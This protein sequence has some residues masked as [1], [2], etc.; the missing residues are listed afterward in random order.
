MANL[1][2]EEMFY[3]NDKELDPK[4]L[5]LYQVRVITEYGYGFDAKLVTILATDSAEAMEFAETSLGVTELK[6]KSR[7]S[8]EEIEGPFVNGHILAVRDEK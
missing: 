3:Y 7:S 2:A 4:Q 1:V 8:C 6:D 5:K